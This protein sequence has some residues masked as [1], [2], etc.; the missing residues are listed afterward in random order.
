MT[1]DMMHPWKDAMP[2]DQ[3]SSEL[4]KRLLPGF[5]PYW[6]RR[7]SL[8]KFVKTGHPHSA[9]FHIIRGRILLGLGQYDQ[10]IDD[11]RS[12]LL[13]DWRDEQAAF[14]LGKAKCAL[15]HSGE[16]KAVAQS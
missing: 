1:E 7:F 4:P 3:N 10:A 8:P 9:R 5:V 2:N 6:S 11:F 14:W 13:L 15:Q 16:T 12:A